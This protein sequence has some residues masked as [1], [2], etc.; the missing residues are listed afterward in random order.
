VTAMPAGRVIG[1]DLGGTKLLA[2]VVDADLVVRHRAVRP[3]PATGVVDLLAEVVGEL[4]QAAEGDVA[5]VGIGM[6]SLVD[7]ERRE[8]V[9]TNHLTLASTPVPDLISERLGMPVV[10]DND[11]NAA[12]LAEHR[13]GAARG[14]DHALLLTLG[15]GIGGALLVDGAIVRGAGGGAGE[16]GHLVVDADGPDCPGNC[17]GRGCLESLASGTALARLGEQAARDAPTSAL[18]R[19]LA[20][21]RPITGALVTELAYDGDGYAREA[22][23]VVGRWLGI[24]LSGLAN[25]FDPE[26]IVIGGGV[27]RA[28]DLL[29]DPAREQL[30]SRALPP[31]AARARIVPARFGEESGMLGAALLA[32][33]QLADV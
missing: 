29:L 21:G 7:P 2:G 6:P 30:A 9:W 12:L 33:E 15:T 4:A 26:L 14:A 28:G 13:F 19:Q 20:E 25:I 5:A 32:W 31:V 16:M 1:V 27:G 3:T 23:A 17:P 18:G 22:V 11:A 10:I 8:V 24:G